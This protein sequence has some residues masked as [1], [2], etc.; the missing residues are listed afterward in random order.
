[1]IRHHS[2]KQEEV[3]SPIHTFIFLQYSLF[4]GQAKQPYLYTKDGQTFCDRQTLLHTFLDFLAHVV[5]YLFY[6]IGW[7]AGFFV[8]L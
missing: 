5:N 2:L 7:K 4:V 1:M 8:G 3:A 6:F